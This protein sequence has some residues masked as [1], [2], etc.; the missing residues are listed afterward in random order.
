MIEAKIDKKTQSVYLHI[1]ELWSKGKIS[2]RTYN[3]CKNYNLFTI[4]DLINF[5][6]ANKSF[7]KLRNCGQKADF[8]LIMICL[9]QKKQLSNT[10]KIDIKNLDMNYSIDDLKIIENLSENTF[11]ICRKEKLLTLKDIIS[12]F[13][14][15][16]SFL[17]I[18]KCTSEAYYELQSVISKN[19]FDLLEVG[20]LNKKAKIV[21]DLKIKFKFNI[22]EHYPD[23]NKH[24]SNKDIC[25]FKVIDVILKNAKCFDSVERSIIRTMYANFNDTMCEI[26][27]VQRL[28]NEGVRLKMIKLTDFL[29]H[30]ENSLIKY[31]MALFNE[32]LNMNFLIN[33]KKY[34][35]VDNETI[36]NINYMCKTSFSN[37][38]VILIL[39]HIYSEY[40]LHN[41][42]NN[43][44]ST[45]NIFTNKVF[46]LSKKT[47]FLIRKPI[48]LEP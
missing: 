5:F 1:D 20:T 34:I 6:E 8:E 35:I 13:I 36:E 25:L 42:L 38:F 41:D 31:I 44:F 2:K 3:V 29:F 23:F 27:K 14:I 9:E 7:R 11:Q 43:L 28:T 45:K 30:Q 12:Y 22:V 33:E 24:Y 21:N 37:F 39:K 32:H 17:N 40:E 10:P 4:V 15:H 46:N 48:L 26:A 47:F 16:K 18:N 19:V